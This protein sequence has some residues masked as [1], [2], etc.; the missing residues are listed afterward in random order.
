MFI[1]FFLLTTKTNLIVLVHS[2][3]A[4]A[5]HEKIIKKPLSLKPTKPTKTIIDEF[6]HLTPEDMEF[7]KQVDKQFKVHGDKIKIKVE[8]ENRTLSLNK[9]TKRT[10]DT[11]TG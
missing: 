5:R 8:R 9:Q 2:I 1:S 3:G 7:L 4:I 11:S 6:R 10:I